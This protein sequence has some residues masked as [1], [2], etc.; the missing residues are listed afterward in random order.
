MKRT[1]IHWILA[2]SAMTLIF[3]G[4]DV[5]NQLN[6]TKGQAEQYV[7]K[8]LESGNL[9]FAYEARKIVGV[10]RVELVKV[11]GTIAKAYTKTEAFTKWYQE[12][13]E[14]NK[15]KPSDLMKT[16]AENRK[17]SVENLKQSLAAMEEAYAKAPAQYKKAQK[18]GIDMAKKMIADTEKPNPKQDK[19]MDEYAKSSN[20]LI[21]KQDVEKLAQWEVDF[22]KDSKPFLKNRLKE[23][24]DFTATVDFNAQI[25]EDQGVKRFVKPEYEHMNGKWKQCFRV[26][27]EATDAGRAIAK[28]WLKELGS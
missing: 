18:E 8:T 24:L 26:G 25:V 15:P 2:L 12:Y 4:D 6:I 16:A 11:M 13:R 7:A 22:P 9:Q 27:K 20:E 1:I 28:D 10:A 5:L 21:K 17:T 23:F 3:A 19:Q 14:Q